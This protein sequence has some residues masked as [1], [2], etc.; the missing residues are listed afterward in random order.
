M[1]TAIALAIAV[2]ASPAAAA[3]AVAPPPHHRH[4]RH[5]H[6]RAVVPAPEQPGFG[7]YPFGQ[8]DEDGLSR[9]PDDCEKGCIGGNPG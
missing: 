7:P 8:G 4:Y 2:A 5:H 3:S 9:D 6:P 1:R